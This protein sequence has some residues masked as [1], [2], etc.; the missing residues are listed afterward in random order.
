ALLSAA[1]V[2]LTDGEVTDG[3]LD[4]ID[5][6]GRVQAAVA[7]FTASFDA[8]TLHAADGARSV[9]GWVAARTEAS[10][11]AAVGALI[12][13]RGLRHCPHVDAA[14]SP[15]RLG[16]AKVRMLLDARHDV[17]ELFASHEADLVAQVAPLTVEQARRRI[18]A[19]RQI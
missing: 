18:D 4:L 1:P 2:E 14:A 19:W 13:G 12:C 5:L 11:P 15:G 16:A 10:R 8:R 9:A 6:S 3:L 17:E 7:R